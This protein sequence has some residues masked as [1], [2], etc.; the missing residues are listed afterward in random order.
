MTRD[1]TGME[2]VH[3]LIPDLEILTFHLIRSMSNS[4]HSK[5]K[6][7]D[8]VGSFMGSSKIR[9]FFIS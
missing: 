7:E 5:D 9:V 1:L 6:L 2:I 4:T 3:I 8:I